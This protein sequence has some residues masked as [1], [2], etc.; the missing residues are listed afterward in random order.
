MNPWPAAE[1]VASRG[2]LP[3]REF[4]RKAPLISIETGIAILLALV[5]LKASGI[6]YWPHIYIGIQYTPH[7]LVYYTEF[8]V[9]LTALAMVFIHGRH[10]WRGALQQGALAALFV[11]YAFIAGQFVKMPPI[12]AFQGVAGYADV[13]I[14]LTLAVAFIGPAATLRVLAQTSFAFVLLNLASAAVPSVSVMVGEF[15]GRFRGLTSHRNDLSHLAYTCALVAFAARHLVPRWMVF[16]TM[17]GAI[18][19]IG[20]ARSVQG[21]LLLPIGLFIYQFASQIRVLRHPVVLISAVVLACLVGFVWEQF[22]T[23]N[24]LMTFFGRDG[25]FSGRDRIWALSLHLI[26]YMPMW[27]YGPGQIGSGV[28]SSALLQRFGLGTMF[29]SAHNAYLEAFLAY[30]WL[31]GGL[32]VATVLLG[33]VMVVRAVLRRSDTY[34]CLA[35][36]LVT[37]SLIGGITASEKLF[38]PGLGWFSFVLALVFVQIRPGRP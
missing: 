2:A 29:G 28:L 9:S 7:R 14:V 35:L 21:I 36:A 13:W 4:A 12:I 11:L 6:R 24:R 27:G 31:G 30:G 16:G 19:L 33:F 25:T 37:T 1:A 20:A 38:M 15:A 3:R 5:F 26:E 17:L 8:L 34:T 23:L 22:G 10:L 18:A 32:F